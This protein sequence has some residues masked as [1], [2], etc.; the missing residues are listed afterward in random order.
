MGY[1]AN[2]DWIKLVHT[3]ASTYNTSVTTTA[4]FG[5]VSPANNRTR[6]IG[7]QAVASF[8]S[9]TLPLLAPPPGRDPGNER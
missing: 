1:V 7:P 9:T 2:G 4:R 8:T 5:G 3:S 6:A